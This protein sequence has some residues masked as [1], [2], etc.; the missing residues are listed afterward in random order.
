[1]RSRE[2]G[3]PAM[4]D[5]RA[6]ITTESAA[7]PREWDE[8]LFSAE[9]RVGRLIEARLTYL[10]TVEDVHDFQRMLRAAFEAAEGRS[11]ICADWKIAR[12]VAPDVAEA[13]IGLLRTGNAFCERSAILLRNA[14]AM[15]SLQV[16]RVVREAG[17]PTRRTFRERDKMRAWLG[18][19]LGEDERRHMGVF[20]GGAPR[21]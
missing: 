20:L 11:V 6:R 3:K 2:S 15:F 8:P 14:D 17:G 13:L 1:M 19:V 4:S 5:E 12:V 16:E 7:P 9:C 10:R 18:E 21:R